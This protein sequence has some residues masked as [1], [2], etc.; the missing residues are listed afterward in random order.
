MLYYIYFYN[1][2]LYEYY[3]LCFYAQLNINS[4]YI[5][6]IDIDIDIE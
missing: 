1:R 5:N 6:R 2:R 3:V 4:F